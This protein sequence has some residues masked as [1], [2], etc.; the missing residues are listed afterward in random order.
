M[1]LEQIKTKTFRMILQFSIPSI[2]AMVLTSMITIVDGFFIGNYIGSEGIAAVNLGLPIIYVYLAVGIMVGV[3]G[4]AIAGMLLGARATDE[5]N[6]V[7]NQTALTALLASILLSAAVVLLINPLVSLLGMTDVVAEYFRTYYW[8]MIFVYPIM[9]L[10]AT[11][12][13]FMRCEGKPATFM[14]IS[15]LTVATNIFLDYLAIVWLGMGIAG[16][17]F[18]S[19][20]SVMLG[21][22]L[23]VYYFSRVSVHFKFH[24]FQFAKDIFTKTIFNGSSELIGQLSMSIAM[25][26]YNWV[27]IRIAGVDGVAAFTIIGYAAYLFNMII[28]GFGQG[29]SPLVSFSYGAGAHWLSQ[30]VRRLTNLTVF[31][32]GAVAMAVLVGS[33]DYYSSLFVQSQ[34]VRS[35]VQSGLALFTISFLFSGINT[36]TSFYFTSIGKAKESALI[37][38][39]RGL[40]VLLGCIIILPLI[41][42]ITGVWLVAPITEAITLILC[43]GL[44]AAEQKDSPGSLEKSAVVNN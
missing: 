32:V 27:V 4:V 43:L 3:G 6:A 33:V 15:V 29:A 8:I 13:M 5:S 39:S 42:G 34:Q 1:N 23:M 20:I 22:A 19:L 12:G 11:L 28:V 26:A 16:I 2:I 30:R 31:S 44:L 14:M 18:A 10:N 40:V 9:M 37:S 41:W 7:F 17:A 36:I 21:L 35:L 24:K 25:F 38:A